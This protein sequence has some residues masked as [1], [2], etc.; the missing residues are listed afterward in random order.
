MRISDGSSDVGSSDLAAN[1]PGTRVSGAGGE[2][3]AGRGS[4]VDA[5]NGRA[6]AATR[7]T[8]AGSRPSADITRPSVGSL[9]RRGGKR[10]DETNHPRA[11]Q[12]GRGR[13]RNLNDHPLRIAPGRNKSS[14]GTLAGPGSN[15][16][17]TAAVRDR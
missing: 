7:S 14:A 4:G 11:M 15:K 10:H 3:A 12:G 13:A 1:I 17:Q 9:L 16:R 8:T 5:D 2:Q 6:A